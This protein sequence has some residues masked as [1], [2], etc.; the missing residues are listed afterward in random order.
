MALDPAAS[1]RLALQT[2]RLRAGQA[3]SCRT[4]GVTEKDDA[5]KVIRW[6]PGDQG[7]TAVLLFVMCLMRLV[8]AGRWR[9]P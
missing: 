7:L 1:R 2:P 9:S 4:M 3:M 5:G 6:C 8:W